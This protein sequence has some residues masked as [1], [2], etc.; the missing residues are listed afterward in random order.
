MVI[1][2]NLAEAKAK[3]S[4]LVAAAAAGDDVVI[5]RSGRPMVRLVPVAEPHERRLGFLAID[6]GDEFFEPLDDAAT[7]DW[8]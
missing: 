1:Q 6:I 4:E 5:A 7:T 8:E 2:M 3:L